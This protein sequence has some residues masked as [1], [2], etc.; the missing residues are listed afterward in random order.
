MQNILGLLHVSHLL[1]TVNCSVNFLVYYLAT[2]TRKRF[3]SFFAFLQRRW[4]DYRGK[5]KMA[6]QPPPPPQLEVLG[7]SAAITRVLS[8]KFRPP[9]PPEKKQKY[10]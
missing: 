6:R 3:F 4:K 8:A 10:L 2:G 5:V 9:P 1:L 7:P